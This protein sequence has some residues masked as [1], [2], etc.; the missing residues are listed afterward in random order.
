MRSIVVKNGHFIATGMVQSVILFVLKKYLSILLHQVLV[1]ACKIFRCGSRVSL[2]L[3]HAG[4]EVQA[5][6]LLYAGLV[7]PRHCG[8]LG[9]Q[10]GIDQAHVSCFG[11]QILNH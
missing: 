1:T 11:R 9:P 5:Q 6:K 10:P 8:I 3:L 7:V 4:S 2:W